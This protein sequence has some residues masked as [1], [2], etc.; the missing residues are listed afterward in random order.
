MTQKVYGEL[1]DVLV[2]RESPFFVIAVIQFINNAERTVRI[3][4]YQ[5]IWDGGSV[6]AKP[7][8]LMLAAGS[9]TE[10]HIR[11]TPDRGDLGA[12]MEKKGVCIEV[13]E[14]TLL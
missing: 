12:L 14:E 6:E 8:D 9:K 4:R 5:I 3:T 13:T 1:S 11:V 10:R 2:S 7:Q